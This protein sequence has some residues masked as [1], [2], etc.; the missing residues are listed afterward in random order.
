MKCFG[1]EGSFK[2]FLLNSVAIC[3]QRIQISILVDNIWDQYLAEIYSE[4]NGMGSNS[5]SL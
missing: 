2:K 4:K 5:I 3:Y 1:G